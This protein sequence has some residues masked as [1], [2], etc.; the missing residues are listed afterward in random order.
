MPRMAFPL[1]MAM[2]FVLGVG[3]MIVV[4]VGSSNAVNLTDG[5]DGLAIGCT[6]TVAFSYLVLSYV[7]GHREIAEYLQE[8]PAK[9][10]QSAE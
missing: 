7:A 6:A 9:L 10:V 8:P 4:L 3:I 2:P 5:L 1:L